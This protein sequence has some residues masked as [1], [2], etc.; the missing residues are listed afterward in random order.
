MDSGTVTYHFKAI[1]DNEFDEWMVVIRKYINLSNE[2]Q[3]CD[4]EYPRL[5]SQHSGDLERRQSLYFKRQSLMEKRQSTNKNGDISSYNLDEDLKKIYSVFNSMENGFKTI[6]NDLDIF[7]SAIENQVPNGH[8]KS[9]QP[10]PNIEGKPRK[11]F[12]LPLQRGN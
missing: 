8:S 1:T 2:R 9:A 12:T 4:P 6:E 11:K 10:S 7:K 3:F 5:A